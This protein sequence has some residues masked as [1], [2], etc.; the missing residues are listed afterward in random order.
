MNVSDSERWK[1]TEFN[2]I[3]M[4]FYI[5]EIHEAAKASQDCLGK[6]K[7]VLQKK[8]RVYKISLS[9]KAS[10]SFAGRRLVWATIKIA[11]S[12][13]DLVKKFFLLQITSINARNIAIASRAS[14]QIWLPSHNIQLWEKQNVELSQFQQ[15]ADQNAVEIDI[16]AVVYENL[17]LYDQ[18]KRTFSAKS[19]P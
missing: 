5:R 4:Q 18:H 11:Q 2:F 8:L 19:S 6:A 14:R 1:E 13:E 7:R 15:A 3:V 9:S 16:W 10:S 17:C 12:M